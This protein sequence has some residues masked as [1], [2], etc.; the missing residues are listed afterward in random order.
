MTSVTVTDNAN[1]RTVHTPTGCG[2]GGGVA[3]GC[4]GGGGGDQRRGGGGGVFVLRLGGDGWREGW[5][6]WE[7]IG[8]CIHEEEDAQRFE[9]IF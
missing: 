4:G 9:D 5:K 2:G 6:G 1:N 7:D 3:G 8:P